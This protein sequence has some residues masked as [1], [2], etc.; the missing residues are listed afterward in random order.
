MELKREI[1][2]GSG[3]HPTTGEPE[4]KARVGVWYDGKR[5]SRVGP[6]LE[7]EMEL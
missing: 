1:L 7:D 4:V 6:P 5:F 2:L 3:R